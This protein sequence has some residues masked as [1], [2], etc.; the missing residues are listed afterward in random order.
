MKSA[1]ISWPFLPMRNSYSNSAVLVALFMS[2]VSLGQTQSFPALAK[3][4]EGKVE[5]VL[6]LR[7]NY[8]KILNRQVRFGGYG[9]GLNFESGLSISL[10]YNRLGSQVLT[11]RLVPNGNDAL[12]KMHY[13]SL[14]IAYEVLDE[15]KFSVVA[16]MGNGFGNVRFTQNGFLKSKIGI[17]CLEPAIYGRYY[18]FDWLAITGQFGYRVTLP[19]GVAS[20]G[21]FSSYKVDIG[22]ALIPLKFYQFIKNSQLN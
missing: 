19:G 2:M 6:Y 20:I 16:E 1:H 13:G 14:L 7:T 22:F 17:Y 11:P 12:L 8:G 4:F 21:D 18:T 5:P 15:N 3:L 10:G 9:L